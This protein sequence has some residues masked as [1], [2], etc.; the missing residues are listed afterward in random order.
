LSVDGRRLYQSE[1]GGNS[2]KSLQ[3]VLPSTRQSR[4]AIRA[5]CS[6]YFVGR[7]TWRVSDT[8]VRLYQGTIIV[9]HRDGFP[10]L[11]GGVAPASR[12]P[13]SPRRPLLAKSLG[14]PSR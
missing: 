1:I 11:L 2:R 7:S 12:C 10:R 13:A 14:K 6:C 8:M 4:A 3:A 5:S 9:T